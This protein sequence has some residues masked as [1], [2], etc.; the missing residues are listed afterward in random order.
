MGITGAL[1]AAYVS[2]VAAWMQA[3][4]TLAALAA[5]FFLFALTVIFVYTYYMWSMIQDGHARVNP[6][7]AVA[8]NFIPI[9]NFYW[10]F[11]CI[12]GFSKDLNAYIDRHAIATPKISEKVPFAYVTMWFIS[13]IFPLTFV[14]VPVALV[15]V[16]IFLWQSATALAYIEKHPA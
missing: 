15:L 13:A 4:W 9:Y 11:Q 2:G 3:S 16:T 12:W 10:L 14:T 8:L 5:V 6:L 1:T 7:K